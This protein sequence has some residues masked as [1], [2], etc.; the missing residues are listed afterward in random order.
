MQFHNDSCPICC[1]PIEH[2]SHHTT[3][4]LHHFHKECY[5]DFVDYNTKQQKNVRCPMCNHM[6]IRM[7][8]EVVI[9]VNEPEPRQPTIF[10][11]PVVFL[12]FIAMLLFAYTSLLLVF[13]LSFN[14][15]RNLSIGDMSR[16]DLHYR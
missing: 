2:G 4:C 16:Y 9:I 10:T 1:E 3:P 15:G 5:S 8:P 14:R 12:L 7:Q 6:L 13:H 11:R